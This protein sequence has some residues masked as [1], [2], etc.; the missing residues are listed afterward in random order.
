MKFAV[1]HGTKTDIDILKA[2]PLSV[3]DS[4]FTARECVIKRASIAVE[5]AAMVALKTLEE[6]NKEHAKFR[7]SNKEYPRTVMAVQGRIAHLRKM[8]GK[9]F[10]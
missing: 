6:N 10:I 9:T 2:P 1:S 8:K 3:T 7:R 5:S 4:D